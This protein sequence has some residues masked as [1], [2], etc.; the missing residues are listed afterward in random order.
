M[1]KETINENKVWVGVHYILLCLYIMFKLFFKFSRRIAKNVMGHILSLLK[2]RWNKRIQW[3]PAQV[4]FTH[5]LPNLL[6]FWFNLFGFSIEAKGVGTHFRKQ[7]DLPYRKLPIPFE[8][9]R[10][11]RFVQLRA[12]QKREQ[13]EEQRKMKEEREKLVEERRQLEKDRDQL[14]K[15]KKK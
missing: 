10:H 12:E 2:A 4:Y 8:R 6:E 1:R 11:H 3:G 15:L 14:E 13:R 5:I 9:E 7:P